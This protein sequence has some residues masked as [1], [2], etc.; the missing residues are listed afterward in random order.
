MKEGYLMQ[1]KWNQEDGV[2]GLEISVARW[3][4]TDRG[5]GVFYTP[6]TALGLIS[7]RSTFFFPSWYKP[8]LIQP[9]TGIQPN[10]NL[11]PSSGN[12]HLDSSG[13]FGTREGPT[14]HAVYPLNCLLH[15]DGRWHLHACCRP[16][17]C[18]LRSAELIQ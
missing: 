18:V 1:F 4:Y 3:G 11:R 16:I 14:P 12:Q 2:V 10:E 8:T 6:A 17:Q 5:S 9:S 7:S 13:I 15:G